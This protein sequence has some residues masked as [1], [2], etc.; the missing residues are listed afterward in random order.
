VGVAPTSNNHFTTRDFVRQENPNSTL[1]SQYQTRVT[2]GGGTIDNTKTSIL[3]QELDN[4]LRRYRKYPEL[5][6]DAEASSFPESVNVI[7]GGSVNSNVLIQTDS[8]NN[9][10]ANTRIQTDLGLKFVG[11][12]NWGDRRYNT[13]I[14]DANLNLGFILR[15]WFHPTQ[16][17][18]VFG[19]FSPNNTSF[20]LR[21]FDIISINEALRFRLGEDGVNTN[22][23][24]RITANNTLTINQWQMLT[25]SF[26]PSPTNVNADLSIFRNGVKVDNADSS[27]G[28]PANITSTGLGQ[29]ILVA[30]RG[31]F[32][33]NLVGQFD[34]I[35]IIKGRS[36][37]ADQEL[38]IFNETR[39]RFGV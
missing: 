2:S 11:I 10:Y 12:Q 1:I 6:M 5:I 37:T 26:R 24:G 18:F 4:N 3:N 29:I 28:S 16:I 8:G 27:S 7:S 32:N 17:G 33:S 35:E 30:S 15:G 21:K 38:A 13:Q 20:D 14:D 9:L 19:F 34:L 39:S 31:A 36:T 22:H 23:F 25:F